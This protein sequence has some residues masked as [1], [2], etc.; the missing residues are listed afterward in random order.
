MCFHQ[1]YLIKTHCSLKAMPHAGNQ[2]SAI[3]MHLQW[4]VED[5]IGLRP[6][7]TTQQLLKIG[8]KSHPRSWRIKIDGRKWGQKKNSFLSSLLSCSGPL[9]YSWDNKPLK[10][11]HP[12]SALKKHEKDKVDRLSQDTVP[13]M[14]YHQPLTYPTITMMKKPWW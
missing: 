10:A 3:F 2:R 6:P 4:H 12:N 8:N 5:L 11:L 1:R 7:N 13:H 9:C 14:F